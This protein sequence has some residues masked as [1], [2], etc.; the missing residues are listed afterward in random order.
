MKIYVKQICLFIFYLTFCIV[1]SP[2]VNIA[3]RIK[4]RNPN[5]PV[6]RLLNNW[7]S[8]FLLSLLLSP[9]EFYCFHPKVYF[10]FTHKHFLA[11]LLRLC[12]WFSVMDYGQ[13]IAFYILSTNEKNYPPK[14][15]PDFSF[16]PL[17]AW[18]HQRALSIIWGHI[19]CG[20]SDLPFGF[21]KWISTVL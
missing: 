1:F 11:R 20:L 9:P 17:F 18:I 19:H 6:R 4:A 5:R 7:K 3:W 15:I 13:L 14:D 16:S 2:C 10:A 21:A 12:P 8:S